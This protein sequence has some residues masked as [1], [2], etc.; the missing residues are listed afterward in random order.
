MSAERI[1]AFHAT[2]HWAKDRSKWSGFILL[3]ED[4]AEHLENAL[5]L[6]RTG[7]AGVE[8]PVTV[9]THIAPGVAVPITKTQLVI[10]GYVPREE[11]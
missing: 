5:R 6:A 1:I 2:Q 4:E 7:K 11:S 8:R 3:S 9:R 10:K